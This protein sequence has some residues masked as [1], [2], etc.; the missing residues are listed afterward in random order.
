MNIKGQIYSVITVKQRTST[1]VCSWYCDFVS[2]R[3]TRF[4]GQCQR[5]SLSF[6]SS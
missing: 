6:M 1:Q 5:T 4:L 2:S 3:F